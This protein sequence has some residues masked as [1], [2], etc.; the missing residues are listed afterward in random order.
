MRILRQIIGRTRMYIS[1]VAPPAARDTN[2]FSDAFGMI[3]QR[4]FAPALPGPRRTK[5]PRCACAN[6]DCVEML[7]H[8]HSVNV[9]IG[10][11]ADARLQKQTT[12]QLKPILLMNATM[13]GREIHINSANRL[14]SFDTLRA[15]AIALVSMY[16]YLVVSREKTCGKIGGYHPNTYCAQLE[17]RISRH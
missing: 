4:H 14:N 13:H 6:N 15:A 8:G 10:R 11:Q 12:D 5:Q 3:N 17:S 1:E 9:T 7:C 16:H 2:L